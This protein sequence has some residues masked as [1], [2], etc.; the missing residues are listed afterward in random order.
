M[1][2]DLETFALVVGLIFVAVVNLAYATIAF[3]KRQRGNASPG[4]FVWGLFW[5]NLGM[6]IT[7]APAWVTESLVDDFLAGGV[8][9]AI[10][11]LGPFV[12]VILALPIGRVLAWL[13]R[14]GR[15]A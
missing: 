6:M 5:F 14:N 12:L 10:P 15:P 7:L 8:T 4:I 11:C 1:T 9:T 13:R 2:L 3:D